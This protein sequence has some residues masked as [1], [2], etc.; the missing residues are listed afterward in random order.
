MSI[1]TLESPVFVLNYNDKP[2]CVLNYND[3]YTPNFCRNPYFVF[4]I[5]KYSIYVD[6]YKLF[7]KKETDDNKNVIKCDI[8][9]V[10][11]F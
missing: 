7:T 3:K 6:E 4:L 8:F 2:A 11:K 10:R 5:F 1:A 9:C